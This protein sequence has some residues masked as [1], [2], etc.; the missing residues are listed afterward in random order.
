MNLHSMRDELVKISKTRY[1]KE[2]EKGTISSK[3]VV[4]AEHPLE[5][6]RRKQTREQLR[7]AEGFSGKELELKRRVAAKAPF[8]APRSEPGNVHMLGPGHMGS[9]VRM[10]DGAVI[11]AGTD[12]GQDVRGIIKRPLKDRLLDRA[13]RYA[14]IFGVP[15][16]A[17]TSPIQKAAPAAE[18]PTLFRATFEHELGEASRGP[19]R[20][21]ASHARLDPTVREAIHTVGDAPAATTMGRL[22]EL[23]P[24]DAEVQRILRQVGSTPDSPIPLHGKQQR[25]AERLMDRSK[26]LNTPATRSRGLSLLGAGYGSHIPGAPA[27]ITQEVAARV[28]PVQFLQDMAE[29][30]GT[31]GKL[32]RVGSLLRDSNRLGR[33]VKKGV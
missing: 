15:P 1:E 18:D 23:H 29:A 2:I 17:I 9:T 8:V 12:V 13:S 30:P 14:P 20:A 19:I 27:D 16:Q 10:G 21:H 28:N 5:Y 26:V 32:K 22:R 24:E 33:Y 11:S 25:A 31:M 7:Q 3:D 6:I 4:S